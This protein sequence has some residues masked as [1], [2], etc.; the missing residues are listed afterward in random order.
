M[1]RRQLL[2]LAQANGQSPAILD[3]GGR[4][5]HY[6]VG[7]PGRITI[8]DLPRETDLQKSLNLGING[9]M[10]QQLERRRSNVDRILYDDMTHSQLPKESYDFVVAVEV[11]EHVEDDG[12]FV[13]HV[14]RVLKPGGMFV[15]TTPNGDSVPNHN[16]D[17]RRHYTREQLLQLLN[18]VFASTSVIYAV[19]GGM[20]R[21]LGLKS[22]SP[23]RPLQ[24]LLSMTGNIINSW[25]SSRRQVSTMVHGTRH[26][27]ALAKK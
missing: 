23:R 1:V 8:T 2:A 26:L 3:V 18:S 7:L 9:S 4:K 17:H 5:S 22:W 20:W 12:R 13:R 10:M 16:P 11:L 19:R 21:K 27:F 25:Q 24:T 14:H 15:M 6:T